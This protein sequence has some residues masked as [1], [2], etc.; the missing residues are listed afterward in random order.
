MS[1]LL[2]PWRETPATTGRPECDQCNKA[3]IGNPPRPKDARIVNTAAVGAVL[4]N[5][6]RLEAR[7][8]ESANFTR[9]PEA[10]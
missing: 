10:E 8:Q 7:Q 5:L 2:D 6:L 4:L 1:R 9:I 3:A